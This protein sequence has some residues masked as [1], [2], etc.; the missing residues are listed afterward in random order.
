MATKLELEK[1]DRSKN[2]VSLEETDLTDYAKKALKEA[3]ETKESD[4][5]DLDEL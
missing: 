1:L 3:R 5:I 4:Y 2:T